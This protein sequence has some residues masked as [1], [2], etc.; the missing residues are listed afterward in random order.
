MRF[1]RLMVFSLAL[2]VVV[3][4]GLTQYLAFETTRKFP[5]TGSFASIDGVQI[6]YID[7]PADAGSED[8]EPIVFLHGA[9][10][11]ARDLDGALVDKLRGRAR[12]IF[13]DRPGAGHSA[14]GG[15]GM[16]APDAQARLVGGLLRQLGVK[17]AIV[18]GHSLGAS[19]AV[20]FA[21]EHPEMTAG[22]V[23][24]SPATHP[25][26]GGDVSWYYDVA[27]FPVL[28]RLFS[29]TIAV[30]AGRL[31]FSKAVKGVFAPDKVPAGYDTR[32]AAELVLRPGTF[33]HN[34]A[35]VSGLFAHVTR[36][37]PR[38]GEITA[39]TV[40]ISGDS[41][42]VVLANIHSE[43]LVRDIKGAKLVWL[44]NTGH[45][46]AWSAPDKVIAEIEALNAQIRVQGQ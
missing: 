1:L 36:L 2:L 29:E 21:L 34:A 23:L 3:F 46:P 25:W 19:I 4:A 38:Y 18:L 11:N 14:R 24:L 16:E 42:D 28:G 27:S 35:D 10:G 8:I 15:A 33:R 30:P 6:H 40:V 12:M 26:P 9:S 20:A 32:S 37:S 45:S 22:L 41:D 17:R 5:P 39:P 13:V 43:G 7:S 31:M 44:A